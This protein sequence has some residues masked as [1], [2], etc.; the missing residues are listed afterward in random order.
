M[1]TIRQI[2]ANRKN[3]KK[4]TGPK[5]ADGKAMVSS[6]AVKHGLLAQAALLPSED[7]E[8]FNSFAD[9]LLAE[10]QPVGTKECL[11]ANE[12]VNLMWRLRRAS[13]IEAGL[14]VRDQAIAEEDWAKSERDALRRIESHILV[15]GEHPLDMPNPAVV[16]K[17]EIFRYG[18]VL[19]SEREATERRQ[20]EVG[21]LGDAFARDAGDGNAFS[22]LGR[23][24]TSIDRRLSKK[25]Q[26]LE[27]LQTRRTIP[28]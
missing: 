1:A 9:D 11:L 2:E 12:I 13:L 6:N 19:R 25:L 23:Y 26:E 5:T 7:E 28:A 3:A 20:S 8:A 18:G 15:F 17:E 22:K 14:F 21:R 27:A 4:S 16:G 10:L 24:E